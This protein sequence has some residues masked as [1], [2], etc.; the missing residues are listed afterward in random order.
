MGQKESLIT[1]AAAAAPA[2]G[3][4]R[5]TSVRY[6]VLAAA[7]TVAVVTYIHRVG[8][9]RALPVLQT[10]LS[11]SDLQSGVLTAAFSLAYGLFEIPCGLLGDRLGVRH[12]LTLL[13]LGW[14]LMTGFG[15]LVIYLPNHWMLPFLFLLLVRFLFGMFQAGAFPSL[16]RMMTDWMPLQNRASAQGLIWMSSRLGGLII[17][18][19][20]GRLMDWCGDWRAPLWIIA[21]IGVL[22]C[23]AFWPWFRNR[24]EEMPG[25]NSAE[26]LLIIK[27]RV[28]RPAGHALVPWRRMLHS[29]SVWAL[30]F[31]YGFG[32]FAANFYVTLLSS[33]LA[34]V[35]QL[36]KD[37]VDLLSSLPF[38]FGLVACAGGGYLSDRFIRLTG[39]RTWGRRLNGTI[40]TALGGLGWLSI[41]WAH[42]TWM[43]GFLLCLIFFANDMAM[44]PAW[45]ACSD[46]GERYAGTLGGAMN[47]IGNILGAAGNIV[48]GY[49]FGIHRPDVVFII[50]ACSFWLATI[51]WQG[52]DVTRPVEAD[53]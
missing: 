19:C 51:C 11:L 34:N 12:L 1:Q 40:G 17:P 8:F 37:K 42:E 38:A 35:R 21:G 41:N 43:L 23:L 2:G 29:R 6:Q 14:S 49:F 3:R 31:T 53:P 25:V 45:A 20:L 33:F 24:P 44:G 46:I 10:D 9:S 47:M 5:P 52:V 7:C 26:R 50:Y 4:E 39:N 16:S 48:A 27:G 36:P 28:E 22:W 13:V 32:G 30:C 15:A 18:V